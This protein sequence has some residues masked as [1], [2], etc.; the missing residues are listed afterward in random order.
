MRRHRFV[1]A[2]LAVGI[3]LALP[4]SAGA[5]VPTQ[6]SVSG[7]GGVSFGCSEIQI[8]ARSGPSGENPTG[9][10][11]CAP[12]F[13]GPVTCL[14]VQGSVALLTIETSQFG[15]LAFRA[16]DNGPAGTDVVEAIPVGQGIGCAQPQPSYV[17]FNFRGD[18][19]VVDAPPLPTSKDQCKNGGWR[20]FGVFKNQGDCVSFVATKGKN[21]PAGP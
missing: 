9:Q 1:L 2:G 10:V 11:D 14:N 18:I 12:F 13:N 16:I 6:D 15:P 21:P 19:V 4:T 7:S 17:T 8:D 3:A 20:A 5:Q